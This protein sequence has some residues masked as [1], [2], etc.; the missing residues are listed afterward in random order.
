MF[1]NPAPRP[2]GHIL[3]LNWARTGDPFRPLGSRWSLY[4]V[5]EAAFTATARLFEICNAA[6]IEK[7]ETSGT[8][9][10]AEN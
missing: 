5:D 8:L 3:R 4:G 10:R 2:S 7:C 1:N 9:A 6:V